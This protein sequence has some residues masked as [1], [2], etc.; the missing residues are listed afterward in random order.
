MEV[1]FCCCFVCSRYFLNRCV[2]EQSQQQINSFF[3]KTGITEF[4]QE[5]SEDLNTCWREIM[6]LCLIAFGEFDCA[7]NQRDSIDMNVFCGLFR[8]LV[9]A[10]VAVPICRGLCGVAGAD[11]CCSC[12]NRRHRISLVRIPFY[13]KN[14]IQLMSISSSLGS[15]TALNCVHIN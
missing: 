2:P 14:Q 9:N 7:P 8:I 12:I 15:T 3:S 1:F 4:F 5:V 10:C 6:Y 11:W 13:I